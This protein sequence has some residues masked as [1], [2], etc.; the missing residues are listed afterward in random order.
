MNATFLLLASLAGAAM[1]PESKKKEDAEI[2]AVPDLVKVLRKDA[3]VAFDALK[4]AKVSSKEY[5]VDDR[6]LA[7]FGLDNQICAL[8]YG[9]GDAWYAATVAD[10]DYMWEGPAE[11][12]ARKWIREVLTQDGWVFSKGGPVEELSLHGLYA[13]MGEVLPSSDLPS[14]FLDIF[15]L[16]L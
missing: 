12:G 11:E 5:R 15:G 2:D 7:Y 1:L 9:D 10:P 16:S 6:F 8:A 14:S 4:Q 3:D 13:C